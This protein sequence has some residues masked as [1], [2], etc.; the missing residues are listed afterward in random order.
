MDE[1]YNIS[2][3]LLG[4][5]ILNANTIWGALRGLETFSQMIIFNFSLRYYQTYTA[6]INDM[7][8]FTHRGLMID[9]AR[10]FQSVQS[11]KNILDSMS[12]SKFNV[13]HWHMTDYQSFPLESLIYPYLWNGSY[14]MH[15][16]YVQN[17]IIE[18]VNYAK[19]LGIRIIA[20]FDVPGHATSWCIGY[21]FLCPTP[22][23]A[24]AYCN[25]PMNPMN[26]TWPLLSGFIGEMS[27]LFI[28]DYIHFGGDEV[29]TDC[30]TKTP[31]IVDWMNQMNFNNASQALQ[32]FDE[33]VIKIANNNNKTVINWD[34]VFQNFHSTMDATKTVVQVWHGGDDSVISSVVAAG[35]RAIYSPDP[36]W[37]LD[38]LD[39]TWETR[40]MLEPC[41]HISN[42]TQQGFVIGGEGNMWGET[43]DASDIQQTV[44]PAAAA[45]AERLWSK[46]NINSTDNAKHRLEYFRCLLN[47]RGIQAAPSNNAQERSAPNG[48]GSCYSQ[49]R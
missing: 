45:I 18:I 5:A 40:Y 12:Y 47:E 49:R 26:E 6:S 37:Y 20:E 4:T 16:R 11:L 42:I 38:S 23:A 3:T 30:W 29:G 10:H 48:P 7:P 46:R 27:K 19:Y 17:D 44:W 24:N 33:T 9:T 13:M 22:S 21:P 35:F 43:V 39:T 15:E 28:D 36:Q 2:I 34:E 32:Y 1:S 41:L 25:S 31:S 14:S 8:R